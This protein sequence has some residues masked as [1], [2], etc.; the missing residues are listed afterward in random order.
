VDLSGLDEVL[1]GPVCGWSVE[2]G[3]A[4]QGV[5]LRGARL[6]GGEWTVDLAP[7]S[8]LYFEGGGGKGTGAG[9]S[10]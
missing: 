6:E 5:R 3:R 4:G 9:G 8:S 1:R 2:A 10:A 7:L